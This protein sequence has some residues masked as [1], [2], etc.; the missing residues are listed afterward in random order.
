MCQLSR[1]LQVN[2]MATSMTSTPP[3]RVR[4]AVQVE[5]QV[6]TVHPPSLD[7]AQPRESFKDLVQAIRRRRPAPTR[8]P[9]HPVTDVIKPRTD[10]PPLSYRHTT[11]QR[12]PARELQCRPSISPERSAQATG[13]TT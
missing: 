10:R 13:V 2:L 1:L 6:Q 9:H 7:E 4:A 5:Q 8:R 12:Q 3:P 11:D